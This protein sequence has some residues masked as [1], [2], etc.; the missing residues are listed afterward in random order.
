MAVELAEKFDDPGFVEQA[1]Q[2]L[3]EIRHFADLSDSVLEEFAMAGE[4]RVFPAGE[5]VFTMNQYDAEEL[6]CLV[7]GTAQLTGVA[8]DSGNL[9]V[10]EVCPGDVIGLEFVLAG[11]E[12]QAYQTG[13]VA[14][15]DIEIITI[16][17]EAVRRA[18]QKRA[19]VAKALLASL[20]RTILRQKTATSARDEN[21]HQRII[22]ALFD[23]VERD[24]VDAR[25]WRI[26]AMPKHRALGEMA[27]ATEVEAAEAVA[28]LISDGIAKRDYPGL[29][30]VDYDRLHDLAL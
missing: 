5:T 23:L 21:P 6:L 20:A 29:V 2:A 18:V 19:G 14:T 24:P 4:R 17:S 15:S 7:I 26:P 13:L 8:T 9:S 25:L 1:V 10:E 16:D 11:R 3:R 22:S 12:E 28:K 30:I 27:G